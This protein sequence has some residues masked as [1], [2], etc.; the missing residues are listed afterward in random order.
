MNHQIVKNLAILE[1]FDLTI[2]PLLRGFIDLKKQNW[3]QFS[4]TMRTT[5][6]QTHSEK[7]EFQDVQDVDTLVV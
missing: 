3:I 4:P 6:K 2:S 7:K 5:G 1:T